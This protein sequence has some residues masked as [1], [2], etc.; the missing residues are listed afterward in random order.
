MVKNPF[1]LGGREVGV[2]H[3][4]CL[5]SYHCAMAFSPE[6]I[7]HIRCAT[8]LPDYGIVHR[9]AASPVPYHGCLALVCDANGDNIRIVSTA[10]GYH[11]RYHTGLRRPYLSG[12]MLHPAGLR[13]NLGEFLL[14]RCHRLPVTSEK[15]G[16]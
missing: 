9:P 6:G 15:D 10:S 11:F 4:A 12:I 5:F 16:P 14:G 7:T 1:Y 2:N 13:K 8:V 3:Q